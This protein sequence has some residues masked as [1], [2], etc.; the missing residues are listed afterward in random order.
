VKA[1][2]EQCEKDGKALGGAILGL[3]GSPSYERMNS[4]AAKVVKTLDEASR[5]IKAVIK[6]VDESQKPGDNSSASSKVA[7]ASFSF[8][9]ASLVASYR[10]VGFCSDFI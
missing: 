8:Q 10:P 5:D 1:T 9:Q 3:R 7:Q 6:I 2:I 4:D